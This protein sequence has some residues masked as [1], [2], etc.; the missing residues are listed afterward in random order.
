MITILA[1]VGNAGFAL[2][3]VSAYPVDVNVQ[4]LL[5]W[6]PVNQALAY[7]PYV[8][9]VDGDFGVVR[10][11]SVGRNA[12]VAGNL[13]VVGLFSAAKSTIPLMTGPI[14]IDTGDVNLITAGTK[15]ALSATGQLNVGA[16]KVVGARDTGWTVATGT[17]QKATFATGSVTLP[18]LAGVVMALEQALIAHGLI[19]A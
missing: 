3:M 17:P 2:P 12:A 18:Q 11:L 4:S 8:G 7:V 15:I 1:D 13:G 16:N 19:G 9:T 10:D 5:A 6:D 14:S